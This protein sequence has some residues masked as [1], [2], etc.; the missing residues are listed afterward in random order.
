MFSSSSVPSGFLY[1][2]QRGVAP[3]GLSLVPTDKA[4]TLALVPA[5]GPLRL[6]CIFLP[7]SGFCLFPQTLVQGPCIPCY[8]SP[9][10]HTLVCHPRLSSLPPGWQ[11]SSESR[12]R[13]Q[14]GLLFLHFNCTL[15]ASGT[16]SGHG[17][18]FPESRL[19]PFCLQPI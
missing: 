12:L 19:S 6:N 1:I 17:D 18:F 15:A 9:S 8:G 10:A 11:G 16:R 2:S 14:G 5:L 4:P 13:E 3:R 7:G